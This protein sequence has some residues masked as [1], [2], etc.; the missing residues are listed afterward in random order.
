MEGN[1]KDIV[2]GASKGD[3]DGRLCVDKKKENKND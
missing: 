3:C 2:E 1:E